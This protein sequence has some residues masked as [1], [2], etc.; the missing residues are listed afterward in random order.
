MIARS[1]FPRPDNWLDLLA[2]LSG[3]GPI[4]DHVQP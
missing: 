3:P 4:K 2:E 1:A